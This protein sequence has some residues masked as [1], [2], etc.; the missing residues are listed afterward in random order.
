MAA[1]LQA[2]MRKVLGEE[3]G[4]DYSLVCGSEVFRV[5]SFVLTTRSPYFKALLAKGWQGSGAKTTTITDRN[6]E[7]LK[8]VIDFMYGVEI[9]EN[10]GIIAE[11]L[12]LANFYLMEDMR[13]KAVALAMGE[14]NQTNYVKI[15]EFAEHINNKGLVEQCAKFIIS[16]AED[17]DMEWVQALP[18]VCLAAMKLIMPK[19]REVKVGDRVRVIVEEGGGLEG[20]GGDYEGCDPGVVDQ[21]TG[22]VDQFTGEV[23]GHELD[24]RA[25]SGIIWHAPHFHVEVEVAA[26]RWVQGTDT[27]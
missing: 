5:H 7:A 16:E 11:V 19:S 20:A 17:A 12:E 13:E 10:S 27:E 14:I 3:E 18:S 2:A 22:V 25:P 9:P 6:P 8:V 21:F 24:V 15:C 26:G 4:A 23:S 1:E